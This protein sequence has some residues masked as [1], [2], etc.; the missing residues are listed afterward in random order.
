MKQVYISIFLF[1]TICNACKKTDI[2]SFDTVEEIVEFDS[3]YSDKSNPLGAITNIEIIDSIIVTKHANDEYYFSFIDAKKGEMI[4]RIG[5]N[6]R[7]PGEY[8]QVGSGFTIFESQFI[9]LD[10]AAKEIIYMSIP[11]IIHKKDSIEVKKESYPYTTDFRPRHMNIIN[12]KK[13]VIGSFKEGRFG[14]LDSNNMIIKN[15]SNYPFRTNGIEGIYRGSVFQCKINSN[16]QKDR[17]VIST[18]S[19]DIFEI[20][21][22]TKSNVNRIYISPFNYIPPVKERGGRIGIDLSKSIAGLSNL[23]VS[24]D[25]IC[26]TYSSESHNQAKKSSFASNEILCFN[27]DGKKVKK[28]ILPFSIHK[29]CINKNFIYGV[30][31][32]NDETIIYRFKL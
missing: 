18:L 4:R 25:F 24:E 29:F 16:N 19:S 23:S 11:D 10:E 2:S 1:L 32:K 13:I 9:F 21:E 14:V 30:G 27:W 5:K 3:I 31:Y 8:V 26:F 20:Y 17:F 22:V 12:N 7:G 15:S 6:G 28:Y